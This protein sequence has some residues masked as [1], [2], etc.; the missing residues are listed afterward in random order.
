MSTVQ[1]DIS[2]I[3]KRLYIVYYSDY[4]HYYHN[5]CCTHIRRPL[6]SVER[7]RLTLTSLKHPSFSKCQPS[8]QGPA[9]EISPASP[10]TIEESY[11][12]GIHAVGI[13]DLLGARVLESRNLIIL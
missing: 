4:Y 6:Q 13:M 2:C 3:V 7:V 11:P 5:Y 9:V 8:K 1:F 10:S 12:P